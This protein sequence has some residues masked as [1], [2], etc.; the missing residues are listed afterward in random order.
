MAHKSLIALTLMSLLFIPGMAAAQDCQLKIHHSAIDAKHH[1]SLEVSCK[2]TWNTLTYLLRASRTRNGT[3]L[4]NSESSKLFIEGN[5]KKTGD[6]ALDLLPGDEVLVEARILQACEV[7]GESRLTYTHQPD[8]GTVPV[9]SK[10]EQQQD[11]Q[12][13]HRTGYRHADNIGAVPAR[14]ESRSGLGNRL[15]THGL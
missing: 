4:I 15:L 1:F 9:A 14:L 10:P 3:T 7:L 13:R 12:Q 11:Q 2:G 5:S 8:N 6:V